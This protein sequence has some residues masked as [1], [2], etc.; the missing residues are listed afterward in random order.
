GDSTVGTFPGAAPSQAM[1]GSI[2]RIAAWTFGMNGENP[3]T[4]TV[5]LPEGVS[6][7]PG[8]NL[9]QPYPFKAVSGHR[10]GYATDCPGNQLYNQLGTIRSYAVGPV[11][12]LTVTG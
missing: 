1:L 11:S 4:G 9:G 3:S 6:D 5:Y 7:S 8:Y 12:G 10:D 2:A